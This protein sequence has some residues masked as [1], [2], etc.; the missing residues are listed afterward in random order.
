MRLNLYF[1]FALLL[2]GS[3]S[4]QSGMETEETDSSVAALEI[5][6]PPNLSDRKIK[7]EATIRFQVKNLAESSTNIEA[8]LQ[9]YG[10]TIINSQNYNQ[11]ES[12]EASYTI[13]VAPEKLDGLLKAIQA[14]SIFLDNKT[15][16]A[17]DVTLQYVDVEARIM[18]KQAVQQKY[19]ELLTKTSKVS[20]ILTIEAE[21]QKVQE[22]LESV[23]AQM[24]AL[25]QQVN[26][27]TINLTMYQLVPVSY[28]DRTSFSTR[29]TSA[30]N[31]GWHLFKDLL[32]GVVY[33]W[34]ILIITIVVLF[35]IRWYKNRQRSIV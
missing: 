11:E 28:S 12:I 21:L 17:D 26:Y 4:C 15:V 34:P 1:L 19:L 33:L 30:L 32:V 29:V 35:L 13:K 18:A 16:T 31:G 8:L 6:P 22:E 23:Q 25:Q 27:S 10:A 14:E 5:T 7:E 2:F 3:V 9:K 24:K 20:E